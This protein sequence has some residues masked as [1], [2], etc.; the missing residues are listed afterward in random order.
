MGSV[1]TSIICHTIQGTV[2][3]TAGSLGTAICDWFRVEAAA[4]NTGKVFLG[5]SSVTASS[6]FVALAAGT[7]GMQAG[8]DMKSPGA[9]DNARGVQGKVL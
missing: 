2:G 3:T 7:N 6:Y 8:Y 4:A 9:Y 5:S 1:P